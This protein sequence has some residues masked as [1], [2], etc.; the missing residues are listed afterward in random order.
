MTKQTTFMQEWCKDGNTS[1]FQGDTGGSNPPSCITFEEV[2]TEFQRRTFR[3]IVDIHHK[4]KNFEHYPGRRI[5]WLIR[6]NNTIIGVIGIASAPMNIG[7]RDKWIGWDLEQ[8]MNTLNKIAENHRF[9]RLGISNTNGS[10]IL[11]KFYSI[12]RNAWK[13]KYGNNLVLLE[14]MVKPPFDGT[15]YKA[16]GWKYIGETKGTTLTRPPSRSL[17]KQAVDGCEGNA[18]K[19]RAENYDEC[20]L[21]GTQEKKGSKKLIFIKPLHR[22]WRKELL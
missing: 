15:V 16:S 5:R 1:P 19:K 6:E 7:A 14:T 4:Y 22:L 20:Y 8:K 12:A 13:E 21:W 2:D 10:K 11:S 9:C 3:R 17:I 18:H